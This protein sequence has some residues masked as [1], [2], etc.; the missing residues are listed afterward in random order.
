MTPPEPTAE[1][2][3]ERHFIELATRPLED[4]PD[5]RDEARGELME[6]LSRQDP[7]QREAMAEAA[8]VRLAKV[9]PGSWRGKALGIVSAWFVLA[10]IAVGLG[11]EFYGEI[12]E[13]KILRYEAQQEATASG[14]SALAPST[15]L[16][17]LE[18]YLDS[19]F[20]GGSTTP[21]DAEAWGVKLDPGN[22]AWLWRQGLLKF[23]RWMA[24][25]SRP[26]E[27]V[28]EAWKLIE[29]AAA[30]PRFEF[31]RPEHDAKAIAAFGPPETCIGLG[32]RARL[33]YHRRGG[34]Q[35]ELMAS[36]FYDVAGSQ[37][38]ARDADGLRSAIQTWETLCL[39]LAQ[40]STQRQD[41][42]LLFKMS[43]AGKSLYSAAKSLGLTAEQE[44]LSPQIKALAASQILTKSTSPPELGVIAQ[45]I[46]LAG[47]L[48]ATEAYK[49]GR[50]MEYAAA[51]RFLALCAAVLLLPFLA[52]LGIE[53]V[54]R[55][56]RVNGLASGL[57]PLF[58]GRDGLWLIGLGLL[59]PLAWYWLITRL[60]PMGLREVGIVQFKYP[61]ILFQAAATLLLGLSLVIQTSQWRVGVR[62]KVIGLRAGLPWLGWLMVGM[63]AAL[64]PAAGIGRW[65]PQSQIEDFIKILSAAGGIPLLWILWRGCALL[66]GP[67]LNAL[68][69]VLAARAASLPLLLAITILL[70]FN[71]LLLAIEKN[72]M[73]QDSVSGWDAKRGTTL[74]EARSVDFVVAR[75]REFFENPKKQ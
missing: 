17:E 24:S 72:W 66:C 13:E 18:A 31:Y 51:E 25:S 40:E 67:K 7:S 61:T 49:P 28:Q 27:G 8:L 32:N 20:S 57:S 33:S 3:A 1:S 60:T 44:R 2:Q 43:E 69:G 74:Q 22:G 26:Q 75:C 10:G 16:A 45:R 35:G 70:A 14:S 5:V 30:A 71:P 41:L 29:E 11:F 15:D 46:Y 9:Q 58:D 50:M 47:P 52:V 48:P 62:A 54:R 4:H 59:A 56:R 53:G 6:R 23:D 38:A 37:E 64:V 36:L 68:P 42:I 73:A 21:D 65:L 63:A 12:H 55:G 34:D 19:R 39:R